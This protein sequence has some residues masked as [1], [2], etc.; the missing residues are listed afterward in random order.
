[1]ERLYSLSNSSSEPHVPITACWSY[2]PTVY[3][4][5]FE[6]T[7]DLSI[8]SWTTATLPRTSQGH[9]PFSHIAS[10][11]FVQIVWK[12]YITIII[13]TLSLLVPHHSL[14]SIC[15][16]PT[17]P[18]P[19]LLNHSHIV[20]AKLGPWSIVTQSCHWLDR[21]MSKSYWPSN[22]N[23]EPHMPPIEL[24]TCLSS[25]WEVVSVEIIRT[26]GK[27]LLKRHMVPSLI[28]LLIAILETCAIEGVIT[29]AINVLAAGHIATFFFR[30]YF[31]T[32]LF[33]SDWYQHSGVLT[34]NWHYACD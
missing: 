34:V 2:L 19:K 6:A 13:A 4:P 11:D 31:Q 10:M 1:M 32:D 29:K 9:D 20:K 21:S 23:S 22:G 16:L 25:V 8:H 17:C 5:N 28:S 30:H 26:V 15:H 12:G 3:L 14:N 27:M 33:V 24:S 7:L 18:K